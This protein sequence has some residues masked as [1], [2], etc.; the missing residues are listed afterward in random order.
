M[1]FPGFFCCIYM[2][3]TQTT[4]VKIVIFKQCGDM[5]LL[6]IVTISSYDSI[7]IEAQDGTYS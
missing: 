7:A 3:K 4:E 1:N 2:M 5:G 6:L